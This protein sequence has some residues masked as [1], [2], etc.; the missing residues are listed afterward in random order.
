[1]REPGPFVPAAEVRQ[2]KR[3]LADQHPHLR[4]VRSAD[5]PPLKLPPQPWSA[6]Q[7]ALATGLVVVVFAAAV[8]L[9]A[10]GVS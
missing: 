3:A 8:L 9:F 10:V 1:M 5:P 2:E 6:E 7:R 4:L